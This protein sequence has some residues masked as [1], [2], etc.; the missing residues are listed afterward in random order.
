MNPCFAVAVSSGTAMEKRS[1]VST[2]SVTAHQPLLDRHIALARREQGY[3]A[4]ASSSALASRKSAFSFL[5]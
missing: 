4:R 3:P 5:T 2:V 1:S